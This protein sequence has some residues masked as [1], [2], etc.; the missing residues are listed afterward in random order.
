LLIRSLKTLPLRLE[1]QCQTAAKL[2]GW[3]AQ[4]SAVRQVY[5]PGLESH[6][7]H[8]LIKRQA[9]G[10]GAMLSFRVDSPQRARTALE[11]IRLISFAESLGG[12]ES[13]LTLPAVQTHGDIPEAERLRLGIDECLLRLSVGIENHS[14][15]QTDLAQALS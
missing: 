4:H 12:V 7:G 11:R 2:A 5:F 6:P 9:S 14:D 8:A 13:L 1:R 3:L 10:F 15:L